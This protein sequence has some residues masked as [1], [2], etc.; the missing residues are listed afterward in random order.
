MK[1]LIFT[2]LLLSGSAWAKNEL[3]LF[4]KPSPKGYDWSTPAAVL[5]SA[6]QNKLSFDSHFMGH[7]FVELKCG[8]QYE[9]TGMSGR[10]FDP[11]TQ[12]LI[13]QRGLGIFYHSFEGKLQTISEIEDELKTLLSEGKVTFTKFLLNDGQCKRVTQY[14]HEYRDKNIGRYYG[15]AHRPRYGEGSGCSAYGVSFLDVAGVMEQEMKDNW[16]QTIN[17][18][19]ELAGPP[20]TDEG[21]SIFK[22]LMSGDKWAS[23]KE[24]HRALTFWN[25]DKMNDWVK[26]KV[27]LKQAYYSVENLQKSQGVV[28]D[29]TQVPAPMGPI[30]LQHTDP[31][32]QKK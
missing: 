32:Y 12:L 26:K 13:H 2:A 11:V 31:M 21:V 27:E 29:K 4:F 3:T 9:L 18:P 25:P 23:D 14:F 20:V 28:F 16:S 6:I 7:V 22:V 24:K 1:N 8:D 5:K 17:I 10:G 30:W 19:L 15:L